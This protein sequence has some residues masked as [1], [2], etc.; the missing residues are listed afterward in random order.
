MRTTMYLFLSLMLFTGC[1]SDCPERYTQDAPEIESYKQSGM[2]YV[3]QDW[4][5]L[6]AGY[7]EDAEIYFN[8]TEGN[9]ESVEEMIEGHQN[10]ARLLSSFG[11]IEGKDEYEKVI[12][13]HDEV[14]VN[15]W[16]TWYGVVAATGKRV[17]IPVHLTAQF[18]DGK[19]VKEYG[20]WDS[21][22]IYLAFQEAEA[23]SAREEA[24]MT[25]E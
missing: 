20:Y 25:E 18:V 6:R 4:D 10:T 8:A 7:S 3:N 23:V 24:D 13:D 14:W 11:F 9:A 19:I 5:A 21:L 22:P 2:A 12:T 1:Q 16:G 17:E 15:Y